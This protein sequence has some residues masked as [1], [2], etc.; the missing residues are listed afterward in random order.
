LR[1]PLLEI[2]RDHPEYGY[3]RTAVELQEMGYPINRKVVARLHNYWDLSLMRRAKRPKKSAV[4]ALLQEAGPLIDLVA[5]LDKIDDFEVLY[6]DFTQIRYQRGHAKA[7]W[8]PI[9]DHKSKLVM[10]HALG[11]S[12]NTDLALDA[13]SMV[14]SSF[15]QLDLKIEG[16]I[17][18][19]DQDGV[20]TGHR[21][22]RETVLRDRVHASFSEEGAKGNVYMESF[23]G[24]FKEENRSILWEQEDLHSLREIVKSRTRYYNRERRLS[25]LGYKSPIK[26]L[27]EKGK[28]PSRYASEK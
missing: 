25:A 20:F 13:W 23:F 19:T 1:E 27:N 3:R 5:R 22:L 18:H 24:R 28:I 21:W 10:G 8:I 16:T 14:R 6:T 11:E 9:I 7:Q 15:R 4:R 12:P 17:I 2:A 26:Y